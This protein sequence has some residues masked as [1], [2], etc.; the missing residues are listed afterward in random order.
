MTLKSMTTAEQALWDKIQ[1]F[2]LDNEAHDLQF[3]DRL[4]RENGWTKAY[5]LRVIEEYR[6]FLFL[7]CVSN[8]GI[9]PSDAVDQAWHLHLTYT[10]SYWVDLCRNTLDR[11][12]HHNPTQGGKKEANKFDG[13]YTD[14]F[15]LYTQKFIT[16][17]PADIW[18]ANEQRFS[19]IDFRRVN[20]GRYLPVNRHI[21]T[22]L[23]VVGMLILAVIG[24]IV[25]PAFFPRIYKSLIAVLL[26]IACVLIFSK[27]DL[28]TNNN[29]GDSGDGGTS[30]DSHHG[31]HSDGHHSGDHGCSSGCSGCSASGC[32][33]CGSGCGGD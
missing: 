11:E 14:M 18:P 25:I 28:S 9:T 32:S 7:C 31:H 30:Y 33:G 5:A 20:V 8:S 24:L 21:I 22:A 15:D 26:I 6:K 12:I 19:D 3:T 10:R 4:A 29:S 13:M 2:Q 17:P 23:K 16:P 27:G 1:S